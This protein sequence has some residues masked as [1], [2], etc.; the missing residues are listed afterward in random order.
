MSTAK[1]RAAAHVAAVI[2]AGYSISLVRNAF[3]DG[4]NGVKTIFDQSP[5][6][7]L[8]EATAALADSY[9]RHRKADNRALVAELM[10]RGWVE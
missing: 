1:Q 6:F 5:P 3:S 8:D 7:T 9:S 4:K 10:A 2:A